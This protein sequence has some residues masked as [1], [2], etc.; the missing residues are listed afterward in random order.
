M[1]DVRWYLAKEAKRGRIAHLAGHW[2]KGSSF[3]KCGKTVG[4]D[5]SKAVRAGNFTAC[6][7]CQIES[8]KELARMRESL[9]ASERAALAAADRQ[10]VPPTPAAEEPS[11]QQRVVAARQFLL[12]RA[13][14]WSNA[15]SAEALD[16][17][18]V[19]A[20]RYAESRN[21]LRAAA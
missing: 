2:R 17:L 15:P 21:D 12:D 18:E 11:P 9:Q 19:A 1:T 13:E 8:E 6:R 16:R 4:A 3:S 20:V 5:V 14:A 10:A 7:N